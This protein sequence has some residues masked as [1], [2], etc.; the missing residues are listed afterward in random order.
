MIRHN[1]PRSCVKGKN[2]NVLLLPLTNHFRPA[3]NRF[4]DEK[5][6]SETHVVTC[7]TAAQMAVA[8]KGKRVV[9]EMLAAGGSGVRLLY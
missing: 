2:D 5:D 4:E 8:T 1:V 3:K 9:R 7:L 6:P